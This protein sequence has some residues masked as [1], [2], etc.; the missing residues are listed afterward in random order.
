VNRIHNKS[1]EIRSVARVSSSRRWVLSIASMAALLWAQGAAYSQA[2]SAD[3]GA[4]SGL[5]RAASEAP[6]HDEARLRELGIRRYDS[7][8]LTLYSDIDPAV[9]QTLPA[10]ID[11]VYPAWVDYFGPLPPAEDGSEFRLTGYLMQDRGLF[12]DTGLLPEELVDFRHG[13]HV[14]YRFWMAEQEFDYYRRHLL[15]HEATHCFMTCVPQRSRP[16]LF[17]QEGMAELFG[18]HEIDAAGRATF[19]S[20]PDSPLR[21]VGFGRIEMLQQEAAAGRF[22]SLDSVL[23]LS[24]ADFTSRSI[25]YAWSWAACK[26]LDTHPRYCDRFR[27]LAV[28]RDGA[29]FRNRLAEACSADRGRLNLEW[30]LFIRSIGYGYDIARSAVEWPE[31]WKPPAVGQTIT[32]DVPAD[33]GWCATGVSVLPGQSLRIAAVGEVTLA[34]DPKPWVSQPQGITIRYANG[35]PLGRLQALIVP[36]SADEGTSDGEIGEVRDVG[37]GRDW[38]SERSGRLW[39]RVNDAWSSLADNRGSYTIQITAAP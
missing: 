1:G 16:P 25:P 30:A 21:Q 26:F 15:I 14:G 13:K 31:Q 17:Y 33:R 39:L 37:S 18:A 28:L 38:R 35:S 24:A 23:S 19:R 27:E 36:D 29:E 7:Q 9:A 20:M 10:L 2:V 6:R 4:G 3:G 22:R 5:R 34:D 12:L 11:A 32:M 8:R